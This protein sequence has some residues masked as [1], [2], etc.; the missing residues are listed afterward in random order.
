MSSSSYNSKQTIVTNRKQKKMDTSQSIKTNI[1]TQTVSTIVSHTAPVQKQDDLDTSE[2][3]TNK[4]AADIYESISSSNNVLEAKKEA[5]EKKV[6]LIKKE[7]DYCNGD[8]D[9]VHGDGDEQVANVPETYNN[10]IS[11]QEIIYESQNKVL[12]PNDTT[13]VPIK[14][15]L[16]MHKRIV[17]KIY[18]VTTP[19]PGDKEPISEC[20]SCCSTSTQQHRVASSGNNNTAIKKRLRINLKETKIL[21]EELIALADE[22]TTK[23]KT[24]LSSATPKTNQI[25]INH[26]KVPYLKTQQRPICRKGGKSCLFI[27]IVSY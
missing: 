12:V 6:A 16:K 21:G 19:M 23:S 7:S 11:G 3:V 10:N 8:N 27:Y 20:L 14:S 9:P 25:P 13:P 24:S 18:T 17:K 26:T 15:N 5:L 2:T 1:D 4:N 22:T